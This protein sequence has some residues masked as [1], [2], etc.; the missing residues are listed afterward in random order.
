MEPHRFAYTST[1]RLVDEDSELHQ[2]TTP[3]QRVYRAQDQNFNAHLLT[4]GDY[5]DRMCD[6]CSE[7]ESPGLFC[8]EC[9]S[10]LCALCATNDHCH[11]TGRRGLSVIHTCPRKNVEP[12]EV[13]QALRG[14]PE[15]FDITELCDRLLCHPKSVK[16][17]LRRMRQLKLVGDKR[18]YGTWHYVLKHD[19]SPPIQKNSSSSRSQTGTP[20]TDTIPAPTGNITGHQAQ[21]P[22]IIVVDD[23]NTSATFESLP[24]LSHS[25]SPS[26][27]HQKNFAAPV[28]EERS[29]LQSATGEVPD[30]RLPSEDASM[31]EQA[32][33]P[34][35]V[36][37]YPLSDSYDTAPQMSPRSF[38]AL[39]FG[40]QHSDTSFDRKSG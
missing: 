24:V 25:V 20:E 31:L 21:S 3:T 9:I 26:P 5:S 32:L 8:Q 15:G 16:R 12:H 39:Y 27:I 35:S 6:R 13:I 4:F 38:L 28:S 11:F 34:V 19:L 1:L 7:T 14:R 18:G 10:F 36:A 30:N 37:Q 33:E 29:V 23:F 2:D 17:L 40:G 22:D